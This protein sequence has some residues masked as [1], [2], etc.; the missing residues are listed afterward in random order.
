MHR[1]AQQPGMTGQVKEDILVRFAELGVFIED[2]R[3]GLNPLI[4]RRSEFLKQTQIAH[5]ID[6]ANNDIAVQ[7]DENAI[8]FS[9]CQV[10]VVYNIATKTGIEIKL[11]DGF[12]VHFDGFLLDELTSSEI[13]KR[14]GKVSQINVFVLEQ[15]LRG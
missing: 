9:I 15:N 4:L 6:I 13:F 5:F 10:P 8:G 3:L 12:K 7:M 2:G 1:G 14:T 11:S